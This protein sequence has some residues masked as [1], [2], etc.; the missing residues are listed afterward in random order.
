M[1]PAA[2]VYTRVSTPVRART[3]QAVIVTEFPLGGTRSLPAD[4]GSTR[5]SEKVR[6]ASQREHPTDI[7]ISAMP[8]EPVQEPVGATSPD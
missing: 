1:N 7:S 5:S 4:I 6:P 8:L 3:Y 2:P